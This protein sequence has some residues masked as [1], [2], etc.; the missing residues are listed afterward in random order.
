L[1]QSS[2]TKRKWYAVTW[3]TGEKELLTE[4][5]FIDLG[6]VEAMDT[7]YACVDSLESLLL[8][9]REVREFIESRGFYFTAAGRDEYWARVIDGD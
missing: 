1:S 7:D 8:T 6:P 2:E 4:A 9:D 3:D 5:E